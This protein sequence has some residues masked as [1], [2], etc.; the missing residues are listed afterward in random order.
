[1]AG[2]TRSKKKKKTKKQQQQQEQLMIILLGI[3]FI[4]LS[5]IS[6]FKLGFLGRLVANGLRLISGNAYQILAIGIAIYGILLI[7]QNSKFYIKKVRRVVG[8]VVLF[9]SSLLF[10]HMLFLGKINY[11]AGIIKAT[12]DL[13][14]Q[15]ISKNVIETSV[16]G[17]MIGAVIA[18]LTNF[19]VD[20]VGSFIIAVLSFIAGLYLVSSIEAQQVIDFFQNLNTKFQTSMAAKA[21]RKEQQAK[22]AAKEQKM[23]AIEKAPVPE[24]DFEAVE[25]ESKPNWMERQKSKK[26]MKQQAEEAL[27]VQQETVQPDF[28]EEE[29]SVQID[30]FQSVIEP[31]VPPVAA[32]DP[33]ETPELDSSE[34]DLEFEIQAEPEDRDYELPTADLL[35][36]IP[37]TDQSD[38]YQKIEENISILERT[39][40]S[41]GVDAK[42]VKASLGP[43]VT[44]YEIQPAIGVKVSKIVSLTDDIA[45]A[46]AAKDI[47]M[48]A[49]IPGKSLIGIEVPNQTTSMV[50]F[51]EVIEAQPYHPDKLL[52]VPLGRDI[53]GMVQVAD[54]SKMPHLLVAGS[55]GSGKS[56]AIN[57]MITSILMRAKPNEVKMMM[58]DPKMVELNV[59]NGI[60]HLLTPV[61]TNPRKAAQALQK[62][63]RE[64]EERYEKFAA[65]G[66]RNITGYNE[67]V[68]RK[69][70]EMGENHPILPF[71]VVIVDELADLMMV[72]SNEVEDAIIRLAQMARAAGIHMIL[73][74]QR[75]SVDV[76]TGIIKAN[77]P[78]RM[79]FAVSS[80]TDSRTIIDGNGAE[81]LLGRGDMLFLPMGENKPIRVQGA[82]IS[83]QEVERVVEF[84][85][86]QQQAEYQ[87]KMMP[88]DEVEVSNNPSEYPQDEL[89]EE[90]KNLVVEMQTASISLLQR[91]FRIG[92][93][94]AARLVDELEAQGVI[95]PSV[96]SKPREV[97]LQAAIGDDELDNNLES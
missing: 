87:E 41:F 56:V 30:M 71:I 93:N 76:I 39:F 1:M 50:S 40:A 59:Y 75:P 6:F 70:L 69:N 46:L 91:R 44:K 58:I 27:A 23:A 2:Q 26:L 61:V 36:S 24:E 74:T 48:E 83:D 33:F 14:K 64:M 5:G 63:V 17:G 47:R 86:D 66:V 55:T 32:V 49:P 82:F 60:P 9:L 72:A 78:S 13:L 53:S 97:Y 92:Y 73:A 18:Q 79:A 80:G 25:E 28:V 21:E 54:L 95:G 96:G 89:F 43:S 77:V 51:R 20:R 62:V 45:L 85:T 29:R 88:T 7:F 94:R 12:W 81:K 10:L 31:L 52:E 19:L 37:V 65:T 34:G 8:L 42:V 22:Q 57:G 90:A 11:D 68:A 67:L 38:E 84:V 3:G 4:F 35:D 16:G 15:D